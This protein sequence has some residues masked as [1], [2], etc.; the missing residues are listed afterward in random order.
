MKE[1][2]TF[3][4]AFNY[5]IKKNY[6]YLYFVD[7]S[8]E[9]H[10]FKKENEPY[11]FHKNEQYGVGNFNEFESLKN[12]GWK[13]LMSKKIAHAN[14]EIDNNNLDNYWK[15]NSAPLD[16]KPDHIEINWEENEYTS[17]K[18]EDIINKVTSKV[19]SIERL[20]NCK[21]G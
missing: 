9:R 16:Y 12:S 14:F 18:Y 10:I 1:F 6:K 3:E 15:D 20:L 4:S 13:L 21:T 5:I 8:E 19:Y 2:I 7:M 17:F 11:I